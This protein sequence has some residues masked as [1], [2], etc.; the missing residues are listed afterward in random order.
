MD[1]PT[2]LEGEILLLCDR[3]GA[4]QAGHP[5]AL[6]ADAY[7]VDDPR[8]ASGAL[9]PDCAR[10]DDPNHYEGSWLLSWG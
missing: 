4:R 7:L 9:C 1:I 8:T 10:E 6:I 3:C 2:P 5:A